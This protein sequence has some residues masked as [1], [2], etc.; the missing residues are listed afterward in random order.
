M[1]I[2]TVFVFSSAATSASEN[3]VPFSLQKGHITIDVE[4]AGEPAEA[5]LDSGAEANLISSRFVAKHGQDFNKSGKAK[6]IGVNATDT[7]QLYNNIPVS[8]YGVQVS[9]DKVAAIRFPGTDLILGSGFFRSGILQIDYPNSRL[10]FLD[11][12]AVDLKKRANVHLKRASG[13]YLP[14]IEV[15]LQGEKTWLLF[16]TGNSG[17]LVLKRPFALDR[18]LIDESAAGNQFIAVGANAIATYERYELDS[19]KVGPYELANVKT[20]VPA[21]GQAANFGSR[22]YITTDTRI[23]RGAKTYGLLGY[24]VLKHF[25]VTVDYKNYRLHVYAP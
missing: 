11:R 15:L 2:C 8:I 10:R 7:I 17:G 12:N 20:A 24:D 3:W 13:S 1:V 18:G 25:V 5:M 4:I 6:V 22:S 21:E 16:D 23:Q 19:I 9:L 14:A